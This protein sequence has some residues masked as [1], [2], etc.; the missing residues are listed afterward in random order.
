MRWLA[1]AALLVGC[2]RRDHSARSVEATAAPHAATPHG[3]IGTDVSKLGLPAPDPQRAMDPSHH[4]RGTIRVAEPLRDRAAQGAAVFVV[5]KRADATGN[6]SGPP[7][8]VR[9][10]A[11]QGDALPFELTEAQAMIGG[12]QLAGDVVV[13]AHYDQ[14]GDALSHQPGDLTGRARATIPAERVDVVLD[15]VEP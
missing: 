15:R 2:G 4:V 1:V 7:L 11:W 12:T 8:A 3:R 6:P 5:V 13:L 10:M 14:D 9:R